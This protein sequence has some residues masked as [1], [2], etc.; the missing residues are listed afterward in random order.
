MNRAEKKYITNSALILGKWLIINF[1]EVS[2]P[3]V[4]TTN[5]AKGSQFIYYLKTKFFFIFSAREKSF[6]SSGFF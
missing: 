4:A 5:K 1:P 2:A 3:I 6:S